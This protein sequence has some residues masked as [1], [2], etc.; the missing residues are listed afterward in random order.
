M[1]KRGITGATICLFL[2]GAILGVFLGLLTDSV[3]WGITLAIPTI[4]FL[5]I[6]DRNLKKKFQQEESEMIKSHFVN[7]SFLRQ[8]MA[9]YESLIARS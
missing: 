1:K 8:A 7:G 4:A 3:I 5:I 6:N 2:A 9:E